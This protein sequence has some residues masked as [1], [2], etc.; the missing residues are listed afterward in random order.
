[1]TH[2][3][4]DTPDQGTPKRR[5]RLWPWPVGIGGVVVLAAFVSMA[6]WPVQWL[7]LIVSTILFSGRPD[8]PDP[9]F[10]FRVH[11]DLVFDGEP[12]VIDG[13]VACRGRIVKY[14]G[15]QQWRTNYQLSAQYIG[16]RLKP[17]GSINMGIPGSTG[18]CYGAVNGSPVRGEWSVSGY[19]IPS[20]V[21]PAFY[22]ADN[23]DR[24][25]RGEIYV[26]EDYYT[27]PSARLEIK[28]FRIGDFAKSL[29]EHALLFD[30][31]GSM[32]RATGALASANGRILADSGEHYFKGAVMRKVPFEDWRDIP[33]IIAFTERLGERREIV[34]L[35]GDA[36]SAAWPLR[37]LPTGTTSYRLGLIGVPRRHGEGSALIF[38][39]PVKASAILAGV[40]S[41][42]PMA[43][44]AG[45]AT[46]LS[47]R[48]GYWPICA[49]PLSDQSGVKGVYYEG[50]R[51]ASPQG[52]SI[53]L[54]LYDPNERVLIIFDTIGV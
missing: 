35:H 42:T 38:V 49:F 24:P 50:Q 22:W 25:T 43:C 6:I 46:P 17:G 4:N 27:Q 3:E 28:S 31:L 44:L 9:V 33:E 5:R 40:D 12:V 13:W 8:V 32:P 16:A 21:L 19:R 2:S 41:V 7:N 20:Q 45:W 18:L 36:F 14:P 15:E 10:Y 29:P 11:A 52:I 23:A 54:V 34:A 30:H 26:S 37:R 48:T 1:M 53:D 51:F 47:D 39:A